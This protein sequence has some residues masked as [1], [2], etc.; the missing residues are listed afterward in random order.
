MEAI[1]YIEKVR[2]AGFDLAAEGDRLLVCPVDRLSD[3]QRQFLRAHKTEILAALQSPGSVLDADGGHDLAAANCPLSARLAI[4]AERVCREVHGD[5]DGQVQAMLD[6][7]ASH[8]PKDWDA[9]TQHFEAQLS[10]PPEPG[11]ERDE[12]QVAVHG[13]SLAAPVE[14]T[15]PIRASLQYRLKDGGGG[16]SLLGS[17][18]TTEAELRAVLA[19][20]YGDRLATIDG[21]EVRA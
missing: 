16:G 9:L 10:P 20:K 21:A 1:N 12:L 8:P 6:D 18:G 14:H 15:K 5:S 19:G 11:R 13:H 2:A 17:P 4:A 3:E 7:L